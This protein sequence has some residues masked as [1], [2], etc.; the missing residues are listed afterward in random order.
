MAL[1]SLNPNLLGTDSAGASKLSTAG[2]LVQ[3]HATGVFTIANTSANNI[4]IANT[5]AITFAGAASGITTLAAGN[6]TLTG[7]LTVST[8]TATIGTTLYSVA[9]GNIGIGN[10]SPGNKLLVSGVV[11]ISGPQGGGAVVPSNSHTSSSLLRLGLRGSV[12]ACDVD[13]LSEV[14]TYFSDNVFFR[15]ATGNPGYIVTAAATQIMMEGGK[16]IFRRAASGTT[17]TD[18]SF[19]ESMR[20]DS[21]SNIGIG[22]ASP[23]Y[24]LDVQ[25][26]V[27]GPIVRVYNGRDTTGSYGIKV[28]LGASGGAGTTGSAH[29]HG[30]TNAVGNWYLYGN[31]TSSYSSD[32][33]LKKNIESARDGYLEDLCRLRVVKYNWNASLIGAP[34]EIGLI[35]QEVEQVFPGLVQDDANPVTQGDDTAYKQLKQS[36]LPFMLLKAIQEL[37]TK[38]EE[39]KASHP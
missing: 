9:N 13:S 29:F 26:T 7:T 14:G 2:G 34:R 16:T 4:S 23:Q 21:S 30:N 1:T 24:K 38:F 3:L 39:Y 25:G 31:G 18:I 33:R 12:M 27:D 5:G 36:V 17:N 10:T 22:T 19:T 28:T 15:N 6:T 8:N 37:N 32:Q 35:A 11:G 20:I